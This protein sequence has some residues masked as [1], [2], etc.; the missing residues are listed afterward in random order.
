MDASAPRHHREPAPLS[1]WQDLLSTFLL[2]LAAVAS[3]YSVWQS[4]LWDGVES[5]RYAQ[6]SATRTAAAE[7]AQIASSQTVYDATTLVQLLLAYHGGDTERVRMISQRVLRKEF[8][9]YVDQWLAMHPAQNP[10]APATPFELPSYRN[11]HAD[12]SH[13][14][15]RQAQALFEQGRAAK[16]HGD[17]YVLTTVTFALVLFFAG[18]ALK[19]PT[20]ALRG[21]ALALAV[22]GM[23]IAGIRL[24][25]LPFTG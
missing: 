10:A 16:V 6:A 11:P 20:E 18:I 13:A 15:E 25:R 21:V 9:P 4:S 17:A 24:L 12:R 23:V 5:A 19:L 2:S 14:L 7:E 1:Y 3:A 22:A 8:K